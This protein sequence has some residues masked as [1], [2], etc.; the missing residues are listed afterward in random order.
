MSDDGHADADPLTLD[1]A[2]VQDF[3]DIMSG[4]TVIGYYNYSEG[5]IEQSDRFLALRR[6]VVLENRA[7]AERFL[8]AE[9]IVDQVDG[10][11]MKIGVREILEGE[12]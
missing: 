5:L 10:S 6:R 2:D 7:L 1:A 11:D 12:E 9:P 8:D 3:A 4:L